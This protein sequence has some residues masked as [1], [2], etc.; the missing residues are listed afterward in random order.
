MHELPVVK[1]I[2]KT[3]LK[4][5][6]G[7]RISRIN[8]II[9]D[10]TSIV[11]ESVEFYFSVLSKNSAAQDAVINIK[12][13]HAFMKC[14]RCLKNYS[15]KLPFDSKCRFCKS[16]SVAINSGQEFLIDSIEIYEK[17]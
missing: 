15:V 16:V 11:D 1:S 7:N 12:R 6:K 10:L 8:L 13:A 9:G 5:S 3:T 14:K 17:N 4:Y 2:L